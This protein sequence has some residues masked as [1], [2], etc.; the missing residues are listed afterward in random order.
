MKNEFMILTAI[1]EE[2]G[3]WIFSLKL[4]N[5]LGQFVPVRFWSYRSRIAAIVMRNEVLTTKI[6]IKLSSEIV[7]NVF[8]LKKI[9]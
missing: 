7:D 1:H 5:E 2:A 4:R 8:E 3:L 9:A 6:P